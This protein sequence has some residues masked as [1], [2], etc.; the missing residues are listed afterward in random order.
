[1]TRFR[2]AAATVLW[3]GGLAVAVPEVATASPVV[4]TASGAAEPSTHCLSGV[5]QV[6]VECRP[7]S[8]RTLYIVRHTWITFITAGSAPCTKSSFLATPA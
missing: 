6:R 4:P 8:G 3:A 5:R 1:M 2:R 7:T